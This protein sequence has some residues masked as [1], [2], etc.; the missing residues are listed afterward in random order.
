MA[1]HDADYSPEMKAV[2]QEFAE[3]LPDWW[4]IAGVTDG[5][6]WAQVSPKIK[7]WGGDLV[8]ELPVPATEIDAL[9]MAMVKVLAGEQ[10]DYI[11]G[12][13]PVGSLGL[14]SA[15]SRDQTL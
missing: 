9:K 1:A 4:Y 8:L 13:E 3:K 2:D 6:A 10:G 12:D 7:A 11:L 15:K 14:A 5:V